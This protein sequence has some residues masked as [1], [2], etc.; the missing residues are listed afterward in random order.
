MTSITNNE[1]NQA[2]LPHW[3]GTSNIRVGSLDEVSINYITQP[4]HYG[5]MMAVTPG[6][7]DADDV[8]K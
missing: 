8:A 7:A 1:L 4:R 5:I 3:N 2:V 6:T